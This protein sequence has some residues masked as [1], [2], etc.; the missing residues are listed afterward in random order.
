MRFVVISMCVTIFLTVTIPMCLL[1][2]YY[3]ASAYDDEAIQESN[4]NTN[5]NTNINKNE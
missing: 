1:F 5:I 3:F 4:T 2:K